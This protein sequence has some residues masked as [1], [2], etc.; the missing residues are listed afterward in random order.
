MHSTGR[1]LLNL[2]R[3]MKGEIKLGN[4]TF[5][6]CAAAVL[7]KRVPHVPPQ[8]LAAWYSAGEAGAVLLIC[9]RGLAVFSTAGGAEALSRPFDL[10]FPGP[11]LFSWEGES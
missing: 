10:P 8:Q 2:W 3:I 11:G 6:S 1:I 4:Y 5:E 9:F 7:R